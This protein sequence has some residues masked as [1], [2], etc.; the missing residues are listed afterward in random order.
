VFL[1]EI[2]KINKEKAHSEP[3][4][5]PRM[6]VKGSEWLQIDVN[7]FFSQ[8]NPVYTARPSFFTFDPV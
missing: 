2:L 4:K 5:W 3:F 8:R 7:E 1:F 6:L